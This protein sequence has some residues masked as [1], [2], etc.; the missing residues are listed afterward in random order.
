MSDSRS[1]EGANEEDVCPICLDPLP[2]ET[3]RGDERSRTMCCG[4]L[5]CKQCA[6]ACQQHQVNTDRET[7]I[8]NAFAQ[9]TLDQGRISE[10]FDLLVEQKCPMCRTNL[11]KTDEDAFRL[12]QKN[13]EEHPSWVWSCYKIGKYYETGHGC[14]KDVGKAFTYYQKAAERGHV[15]AQHE[16]GNCYESGRGVSKS[17]NEAIHWYTQAANTGFAMSQFTLGQIYYEQRNFKE[18]VRLYT[19]GAEQGFDKAQCS[20][21]FCYEHGEG[22]DAPSLDQSLHWNKKAAEGGNA[23][24]MA[25][26][27]GNLLGTAAMRYMGRV[28]LAGKSV[29]P[30]VLYWSRKAV[31]AGYA[32]AESLMAQMEASISNVCASCEMKAATAASP[33]TFQRCTQCKAAYYCGKDC[34][35]AHWK[36]GHKWDCVNKD[37]VKRSHPSK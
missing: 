35:M 8:R 13:V 26:Y 23:T 21:A 12:V 28:D 2:A 15:K 27:A 1:Q 11:P 5:I 16:L 24:A 22:V 17:R 9:G 34:Q 36:K 37:G 30:E 7:I 32:D 3:W 4:N 31:A 18:A 14:S 33:E 19:L 20:L 25:N 6:S 29:V 10:C